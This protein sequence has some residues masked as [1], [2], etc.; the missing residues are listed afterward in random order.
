MSSVSLSVLDIVPV[1]CGV[2]LAFVSPFFPP[3]GWA[4]GYRIFLCLISFVCF[5]S[6]LV[7]DMLLHLLVRLPFSLLLILTADF[8]CHFGEFVKERRC[9]GGDFTLN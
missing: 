6:S 1:F 8:Y 4:C 2:G 3:S 7:G 5:A 9:C